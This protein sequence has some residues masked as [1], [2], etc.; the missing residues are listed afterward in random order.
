MCLAAYDEHDQR[1]LGSQGS[2]SDDSDD[3]DNSDFVCWDAN[4]VGGAEMAFST[5]SGM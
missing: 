1:D 3:S 2:E 4:G 5:L